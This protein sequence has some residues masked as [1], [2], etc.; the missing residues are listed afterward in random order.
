MSARWEYLI[1][2]WQYK[3]N[4]SNKAPTEAQTWESLYRVTRPGREP[5]TFAAENVNWSELLNELGSDGWE[6]V[7]ESL[8]KSVIYGQSMGWSNVGSP[9]EIVW[10]F[11][12]LA[13]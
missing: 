2:S 8:R 4:W 12:R 7:T 11:K 13:S 6:M 1:V 3:T 10:H 9:V 5:E